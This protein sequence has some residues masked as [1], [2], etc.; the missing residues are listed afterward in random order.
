MF[1]GSTFAEILSI[2]GKSIGKWFI[3]RKLF[4]LLSSFLYSRG[5]TM[6]KCK[7]PLGCHHLGEKLLITM[8][9]EEFCLI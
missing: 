9:V 2:G 8:T 3:C 6:G 7:N 1:L 4:A 5:L